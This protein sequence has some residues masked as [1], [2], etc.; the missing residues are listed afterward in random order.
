M[1]ISVIGGLFSFTS[2]LFFASASVILKRHHKL[3]KD[4]GLLLTLIVNNC[5]NVAFI[6]GMIFIGIFPTS[7]DL[8]AVCYFILGGVLTSLVGRSCLMASIREMGPTKAVNFKVISPVVT[9]LA[10]VFILHEVVSFLGVLG[11]A[12]VF[13]GLYLS[14]ARVDDIQEEEEVYLVTRTGILMGISTGLC[15]GFGNLFRKLGVIIMPSSIIGASIGCIASM[16][17]LIIYL[18][19]NGK[20]H[21][22]ISMNKD[23]AKNSLLY[24]V[25]STGAL[26]FAFLGVM[27]FPVAKANVLL[28]TE[29]ILTILLIFLF[30]KNVERLN[31]KAVFASA[32]VVTGAII[33]ILT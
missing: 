32:V 8:R 5:V 16:I 25:L 2:A 28:S 4:V 15:I 13:G 12:I 10:G 24:G 11:I 20:L 26:Y 23:E 30:S 29:P 22:L 14:M 7:W 27:Y 3:D 31:R 18:W 19:Y 17:G 1:E 33:I 6:I 21:L 9:L